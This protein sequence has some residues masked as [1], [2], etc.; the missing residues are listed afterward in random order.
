MLEKPPTMIIANPIY[1][2]AFKYLLED[3]EIAKGLIGLIIGE[4]IVELTLQPQEL[5]EPNDD[6][7]VIVFRI[8]FKA[9]IKTKEGTY[10][11]VL[12]EIQKSRNEKDV[13]RFRKYLA[14]NYAAKDEVKTDDGTIEAKVLPII[15]IYFL[16]FLLKDVETTLVRINRVYYDMIH[17]KEL[18]TKNDFIEQLTHNGYFLQIPRLAPNAKTEIERILTVFNQ[19]YREERDNHLL[20]IPEEIVEA[21]PLGRQIFNRLLWAGATPALLQKMQI[22]EELDEKLGNRIRE[23][24]ELKGKLEKLEK[25]DDTIT[26]AIIKFI[27]LGLT[28][29][30]IATTMNITEKEVQLVREQRT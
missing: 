26:K 3:T 1:D 24:S 11:K 2:A 6:Y 13:L 25:K 12:I 16:N 20:D 10:K 27:E 4:E 22:E 17:E 15:S 23:I 8:D 5:L 29:S 28:N 9:I 7:V 14:D 18:S 21:Y 30:V 19:D